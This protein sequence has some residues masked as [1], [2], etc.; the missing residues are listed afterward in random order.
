V[1]VLEAVADG[2]LGGG[3]THVLQLIE[4]LRADLGAEVHLVS[5]AG[6]AA[7][8]EAA[9][10]GAGTHGLDF[11]RTRADPRL[12][13]RLRA[14]VR[15]LRPA[16]IH[17]HGA[18]AGL[19]LGWAKGAVPMLYSVHGYHFVARAGP[20]RR[21]AIAAERRCSAA[22]LATVFVADG[23]RAVAKR[24]GILGACRRHVLIPNGVDLERLPS[25]AAAPDPFALAF[26]GRLV[27]QKNP[28]AL[29]DILDRLR[30]EPFRLE[31]IGD[32]PLRGGM[33]ARAA[34]LGLRDRVTFHG[35]LPHAEGLALLAGQ[36]ALLLP[37]AWEGLPMAVLEAMALGVPA[38]ASAVGG[39]PEAVEDGQSGLL[40]APGDLDGFTAAV[41]R[42]AGDA[43]LRARI[44]A[45][46]RQ[47]VAS[48]FSWQAGRR[49]YLDLYRET[50]ADR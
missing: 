22:A 30:D 50:L 2:R 37:S 29:L 34:A 47:T 8:A 27:G 41:R 7:L 25:P 23:D 40:C 20:L 45:A 35:A 17:A 32:G 10:L 24:T 28:L 16:L 11:F 18:R 42:L 26:L 6:S 15:R 48:R 33:A 49:A 38:V 5:Q 9:R 39:I 3:T 14:L 31:V 36:G 13:W 4:A 1:I 44:T 12:W 21:L 19:P 43:D 46:A